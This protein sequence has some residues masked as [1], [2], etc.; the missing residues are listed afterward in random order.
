MQSGKSGRN[1]KKELALKSALMLYLRAACVESITHP[2]RCASLPAG[3]RILTA[4]C[5]VAS[6]Q[7]QASFIDLLQMY[8]CLQPWPSCNLAP[9]LLSREIVEKKHGGLLKGG[10]ETFKSM[11]KPVC[12][13]FMECKH[14]FFVFLALKTNAILQYSH[15][16]LSQSPFIMT[17]SYLFC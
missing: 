5:H 6:G 13:L 2:V 15:S 14:T 10:K 9:S 12:T 7:T 4:S 1:G 11:W 8:L 17:L 16:F 3:G